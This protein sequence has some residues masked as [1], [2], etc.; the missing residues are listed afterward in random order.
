MAPSK[1]LGKY[2][3]N[4]IKE[5]IPLKRYFISDSKEGLPH[6]KKIILSKVIAMLRPHNKIIIF[7]G[8]RYFSRIS[9]LEIIF[10]F[11]IL[12]YQIVF[13]SGIICYVKNYSLVECDMLMIFLLLRF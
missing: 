10:F 12:Y 5:Y 2:Y 3:F 6:I 8:K 4:D 7:L 1:I 9:P 11:L 13:A